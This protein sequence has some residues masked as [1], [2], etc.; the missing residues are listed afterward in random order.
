[1]SR[2]FL[3]D[4]GLTDSARAYDSDRS[5][6]SDNPRTGGVFAGADRVI[7]PQYR[8]Q[9]SPDPIFPVKSKEQLLRAIL[10]SRAEACESGPMLNAFQRSR[11]GISCGQYSHS[12]PGRQPAHWRV[13]VSRTIRR[14]DKP[15]GQVTKKQ[16]ENFGEAERHVRWNLP[17]I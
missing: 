11:A 14:D 10:A 2:P 12:L 7:A 15:E 9:L 5:A 1:M 16:M 17:V 3:R 8:L 13:G 4:S 6:S